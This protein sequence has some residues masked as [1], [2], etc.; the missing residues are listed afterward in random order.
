[1]NEVRGGFDARGRRFAV[2][3]SSFNE[4]VVGKLVE[5]ALACFRAHG[6][7]EDDLLVAWVPGA[8]ELPLVAKRL[9]ESERYDAVVCLGAVIRGETVHFD[10]VAGQAAQGIQRVALETGV[11]VAFGVLTTDT[12]EQA[13]DRAGGKHGNKG[14]D[15]AMAAMQMV[16]VLDQLAAGV[17]R[18]SS[19]AERSGADQAAAVPLAEAARRRRG[20]SGKKKE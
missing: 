1:V 16:S 8:F 19:P 15:A 10:H 11:P 14:W 3:A 7:S 6:V 13:L 20:A 4:L 2:S 18:G 9:A 5:A 12:I 17:Q